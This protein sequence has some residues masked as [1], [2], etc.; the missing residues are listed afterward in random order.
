MMSL[1][2]FL[3]QF[4]PLLCGVMFY[5][6]LNFFVRLKWTVE[7]HLPGLSSEVY[8]GAFGWNTSASA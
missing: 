8:S 6:S 3:V 5:G 2:F 4:I 7:L 1:T